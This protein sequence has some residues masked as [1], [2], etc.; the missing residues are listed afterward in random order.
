MTVTRQQLVLAALGL[1][2][3]LYQWGGQ[4]YRGDYGTD[5]SGLV[6]DAFYR[7]G[8][9]SRGL[10][11]GTGWASSTYA[12]LPRVEQPQPGDLWVYGDPVTHVTLHLGQLQV[13]D[14]P[15]TEPLLLNA[16]GGGQDVVTPEIARARR[17]RVVLLPVAGYHQRRAPRFAVSMERF[18]RP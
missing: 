2:G 17:A 9:V 8:A 13:G 14:F 18:F 1:Q 12:T 6:G 5:C 3:T 15:P 4:L 11:L 7:A 10:A 16:S